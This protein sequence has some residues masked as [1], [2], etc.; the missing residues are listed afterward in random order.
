MDNTPPQE[1]DQPDLV[2]DLNFVPTWAREPAGKNPYEHFRGR[3]ERGGERARESR[4]ARGGGRD[5]DR[6]REGGGRDPRGGK[7]GGPG[8][9]PPRGPRRERRDEFRRGAAPRPAPEPVRIPPVEVNFLPERQRLGALARDIQT[10]GR[11]FPLATLAF[12]FLGNPAFYL[13]KLEAR[14]HRETRQVS[15]LFQCRECKI[16]FS[17]KSA[18]L[19]HAAAAHL[20]LAFVREEQ[21]IEPPAG[22]F[23]CVAR[24]KL[25]RTLL[26]PPN[27]HG[28]NERVRELHRKEFPHLTLDEYR[29]HIETV[30]DPELIEKWKDE[31]RKQVVY[32][33]RGAE[34]PPALKLAE[35][36][37]IFL[38]QHAPAMAVDISRVIVP[39]DVAQRFEDPGLRAAVRE[40]W[41]RESQRPYSLM[42][43][44]RPAFHHMRL[45]LFKARGGATFVTQ[46]QPHPMDPHQAVKTIADILQYLRK[47]PGCT[48]QQMV[49]K[50]RPG[51]APE[52][53]E[54]AALITPLRWL[55]EKGHV[56]EFFN[57]TL[58]VPSAPTPPSKS[59][60][61]AP[62]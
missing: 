32:R 5:R 13:V 57:G 22:N 40:A 59:P 11:A 51:A 39:A 36:Q 38:D 54:V 49:E 6:R 29:S 37:K 45:F 25:S 34:N 21:E 47:H 3:E 53:S 8:F 61:P 48:R 2:L 4:G 9:G 35:A 26:G 24:C 14:A 20:E 56:I 46:I 19:A 42:L 31:C 15:P 44:L 41:S 58:S 52:S 43:A 55:I 12:R 18:L 62:A 60:A 33:L 23:M 28:Y 27:Y 17:D 16:V 50:L 10:S 30:H 7:P 1:R